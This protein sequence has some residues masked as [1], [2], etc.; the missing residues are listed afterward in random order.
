MSALSYSNSRFATNAEQLIQLSYQVE[1]PGFVPPVP[2]ADSTGAPAV[3][4]ARPP[5]T[6][7]VGAGVAVPSE[8]EAKARAQ[9]HLDAIRETTGQMFA[10]AQMLVK[11]SLMNLFFDISDLDD[12]F[13]SDKQGES[14]DE[15]T[16]AIRTLRQARAALKVIT[17]MDGI[18]FGVLNTYILPLLCAFLGAAAYGL[19]SL[20]EK[21]FAR[22]YRSTYASFARAILA[23][24]V[25]FAVGLFTDFTA[26]LSIQPLAV[27][28]I[29]GYAVE[30]FFIFLDTILQAIQKPRTTPT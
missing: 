21:T 8:D 29:A 3:V 2:R 25:G 26:K 23:V 4:I 6:P 9:A 7:L 13:D 18:S 16:K 12:L 22:T 24:I 20:S 11:L 5:L 14:Q 10:N 1:Q 19:R 17:S 30:S 15:Q 28:F 27:A